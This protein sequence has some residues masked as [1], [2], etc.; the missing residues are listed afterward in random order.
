MEQSKLHAALQALTARSGTS[1]RDFLAGAASLGVS[2]TLAGSVWSEARA[3][4]PQKGG[5]LKA[6]ADG[7]A[8]SDTFVPLQA[9]GADHPTLAILSSFDTLTEIDGNGAPQPSLA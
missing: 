6:A 2:V 5:T 7:G 3:A 9:L 1:R 4:T 8:T